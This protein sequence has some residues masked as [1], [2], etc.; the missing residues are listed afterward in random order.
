MLK[1]TGF[2]EITEACCLLIAGWRERASQII[3]G[4]EL[5]M[6]IKYKPANDIDCEFTMFQ[7]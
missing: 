5:K 7:T 3:S 6:E 1:L 2:P 4:F